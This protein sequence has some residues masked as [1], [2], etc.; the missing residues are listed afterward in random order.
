MRFAKPF[1][2]DFRKPKNAKMTL[3]KRLKA[4]VKRIRKAGIKDEEIALGFLDESGVQNKANTV[5]VWSFGKLNIFKNT[6][7]FHINTIGFYAIQGESCQDFLEK[8]NGTNVNGFFSKVREANAKYKAVIVVLDNAPS[9]IA[10]AARQGCEEA[11]IYLLYLPPYSPDLNPIEFLWKSAKR[12]FSLIFPRDVQDMR[13]QI[14]RVWKNLCENL[15]FAS[16][17]IRSFLN[18]SAHSFGFRV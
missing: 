10:G 17:W 15:G 11:G 13:K 12:F 4:I 16:S 14:S 7:K 5:R 1:P 3:G 18:P 6:T 8:A 9:H 2:H